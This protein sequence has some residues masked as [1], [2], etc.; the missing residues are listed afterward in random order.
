MYNDV[1]AILEKQVSICGKFPKVYRLCIAHLLEC[2]S[3][4]QYPEIISVKNAYWFLEAKTDYLG[5]YTIMAL[6]LILRISDINTIFFSFLYI[7]CHY[8]KSKFQAL[9]IFSVVTLSLNVKQV[10]NVQ[11]VK[12]ETP[13]T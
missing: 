9:N 10:K 5:I 7:L 11:N 1:W 12:K 3:Q 8:S 4:A 13:S 6:N 2:N